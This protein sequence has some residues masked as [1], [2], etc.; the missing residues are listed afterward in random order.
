M[1]H[2]IGLVRADGVTRIT[3]V[4]RSHRAGPLGRWGVTARTAKEITMDARFNYYGNTVAA[5]FAKYINS[6]GKAVT[7]SPCR[8]RP[9]SW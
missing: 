1:F 2:G 8:P 5:K 4:W 7:D 3:V 6:A 9:R